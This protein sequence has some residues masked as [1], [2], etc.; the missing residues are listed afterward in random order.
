MEEYE[1]EKD[2]I[3]DNIRDIIE[4]ALRGEH[5][6][7]VFIRNFSQ[8]LEAGFCIKDRK[9]I[10]KALKLIKKDIYSRLN[11]LTKTADEAWL[12]EEFPFMLMLK[13]IEVAV[14]FYEEDISILKSMKN[15]Y[16]NYIFSGHIVDFLIGNERPDEDLFDHR[17]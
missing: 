14:K 17:R 4:N 3:V 5:S 13:K 2:E 15:E 6:E 8:Y 12:T 1:L 16:I 9:N 7:F 10:I 11:Y